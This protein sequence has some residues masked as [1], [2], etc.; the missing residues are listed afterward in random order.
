MVPSWIDYTAD[1]VT[2]EWTGIE[3]DVYI[4]TYL[5]DFS[6]GVDPILGYVLGKCGL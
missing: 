2:I 6:S 3:P 4:D 5:E 1:M